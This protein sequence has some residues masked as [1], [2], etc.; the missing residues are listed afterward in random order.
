MSVTRIELRGELKIAERLFSEQTRELLLLAYLCTRK[1]HRCSRAEVA[2]ALWPD[3]TRAH[4]L[5]SLR[6]AISRAAKLNVVHSDRVM[7]WLSD[8]TTD[9]HDFPN[10]QAILPHWTHHWVESYR[11]LDRDAYA[12]Q[13]LMQASAIEEPIT[14]IA[15]L[16]DGLR[17]NPLDEEVCADLIEIYSQLGWQTEIAITLREFEKNLAHAELTVSTRRLEALIRPF[18]QELT[19]NRHGLSIAQN[20]ALVHAMAPVHF[21]TGQ[22]H[23]AQTQL[24]ALLATGGST[25]EQES[26]TAYYLSKAL[27]LLGRVGEAK[28]CAADHIGK[29]DSE[30]DLLLR[31]YGHYIADRFQQA[32]ELLANNEVVKDFTGESYCDAMGILCIAAGRSHRDDAA[33]KASQHGSEVAKKIGSKYYSIVFQGLS[34]WLRRESAE[35]SDLITQYRTLMDYAERWNFR[36]LKA[37]YQA[38]IGKTQREMGALRDAE[39]T[40]LDCV[41]YC[42]ESRLTWRLGIALDYLGEVYLSMKRYSEAALTFQRSVL[43]RRESNEDGARCTGLRGAGLA[44][45]GLHDYALAKKMFAR[46]LPIYARLGHVM[47]YGVCAIYLAWAERSAGDASAQDS[48][49]RGISALIKS[50]APRSRIRY[51]VGEEMWEAIATEHGFPR[52]AELTH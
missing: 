15:T 20:I 40:L 28:K 51:E 13:K 22:L 6:Q 52:D 5:N 47:Q 23:E 4:Q 38:D 35:Q 46:C 21:C 24:S 34:L 14:K 29:S 2:Q 11:E 32:Y 36:A 42:D 8:V 37:G 33:L 3:S 43:L 25:P 26:Q 27:F 7:V 48:W 50:G 39:A 1:G 12:T 19:V 30:Y 44:L 45:M 18:K 9:L 16:M 49:Q 10:W 31:A 41:A 17:A